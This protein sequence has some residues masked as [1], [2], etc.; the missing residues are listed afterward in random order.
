MIGSHGHTAL[1]GLL[2]GSV[3]DAVLAGST[4]PLLVVRDTAAPKR[5]SLAVGIALDGSRYGMAAARYALKHQRLIGMAPRFMLIHVVPDRAAIVIPGFGDAPAPL[6]SA[7]KIVAAQ[8]AAFD[9]VMAPAR[10]LFEQTE[11]DVEAVCRAANPPGDEIAALAKQRKLDMPVMSSRGLGALQSVVLGSVAAR[12]AA[13]CTTPLL[14][15]RE[16]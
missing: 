10:R 14:P 4:K 11:L 5:T 2:F 1:K 7:E 8:S 6:Y 3:T 12:V 15:A 9:R 16:M 13:R